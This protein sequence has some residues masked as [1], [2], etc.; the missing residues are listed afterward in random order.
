M[1]GTNCAGNSYTVSN[2]QVTVNVNGRNAVGLH[3]GAKPGTSGDGGSTT[4]TTGATTVVP[5]TSLPTATSGTGTIT[6]SFS[7]TATTYFGQVRFLTFPF[8]LSSVL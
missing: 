6:I 7:V 8:P 4:I 2:G 3:I 1:S 5:T